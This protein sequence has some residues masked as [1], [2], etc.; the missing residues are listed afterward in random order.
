[1]ISKQRTFAITHLVLI[2]HQHLAIRYGT[3]SRQRIVNKLSNVTGFS[4]HITEKRTIRRENKH[5]MKRK[6]KLMKL[7][8]AQ[9]LI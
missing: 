2:I 3:H 8:R 7:R 5:N 6:A 1:M 9:Y 4:H